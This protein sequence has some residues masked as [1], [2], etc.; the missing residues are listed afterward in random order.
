MLKKYTRIEIA[1]CLDITPPF[2]M[3]DEYIEVEV[4]KKAIGTKMLSSEEWSLQCHLPKMQAM[5]ATLQTEGM[6]QTLVM[7]IYDTVP[8][9][10]EQRALVTNS[11]VKFLSSPIVGKIISY[12]A[13]LLSFR[14]GIAKGKVTAFS[15][16]NV[17]SYG[18]FSYA[19]PHL[20]V[21]RKDAL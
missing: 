6:L 21:F 9:S 12:E 7:L 20:M 3:I 8:H 16:E 4:G 18:E 2:L 17:I 1:D 15:D 13:E 5:P 14:R 10:G 11:T 19:S